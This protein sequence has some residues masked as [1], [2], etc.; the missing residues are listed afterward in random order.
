M[1]PVVALLAGLALAIAPLYFEALVI[2]AR[3]SAAERS[4]D[5]IV[6]RIGAGAMAH[7]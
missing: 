1:W 4:V 5:R 3:M 2:R 7:R 6:H